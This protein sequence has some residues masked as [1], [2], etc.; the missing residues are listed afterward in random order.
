MLASVKMKD[1]IRPMNLLKIGNVCLLLAAAGMLWTEQVVAGEQGSN[2]VEKN[3]KPYEGDWYKLFPDMADAGKERLAYA[4]HVTDVECPKFQVFYPKGWK[5]SDRRPALVVFPGGGYQV[6]NLRGEGAMVAD[7]AN[8]LGMVAAIVKYRVSSQSNV[9]TR[10]P[11]PLLDARQAMRIVRRDAAKLGVH[12]G[13]VGVIGFSAGGNVAAMTAT[14]WE[15]PLAGEQ[16]NGEV[17]TRPDF[18]MLI[19]PV[20]TM[21]DGVTHLGSRYQLF[22]KE[23]TQEQIQKYSTEKRVTPQTPPLFLIQSKDDAVSCR[24]S[25]LMEQ[26]ATANGVEATRIL[27]EKGG[28]GYGMEKR[29]NPTD[30]WPLE[31]EKWLRS[32]GWTQETP[33]QR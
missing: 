12:P 30:A 3:S 2:V 7:W 20:I 10:F 5:A 19:Y 29:N 32:H 22:G 11:G 14:M 28:H 24:N 18:A 9:V 17:S 23:V 13:K 33:P 16:A 6:L 25:E 4:G 26:A 15:E 27:Y 1:I 31:A 21:E 8:R